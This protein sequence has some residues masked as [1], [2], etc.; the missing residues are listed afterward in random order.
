MTKPQTTTTAA[1]ESYWAMKQRHQ[2]EYSEFTPGKVFFAF[3][4]S[5]FEEGMKSIGLQPT[6]TNKIYR[7]VAGS[8]IR[9][10]YSIE[11]REL[12][13]RFDAEQAAAIA[14]DPT[15]EG[16][17]YSMFYD[18]LTNHEYCYSL[19]SSDALDALGITI[20]DINAD[21]RMKKAFKRAKVAAARSDC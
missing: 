21:E 12:F 1:P 16:F 10:E 2:R 20:D 14:A 17:I 19:D 4:N 11:Q 15:G 13:E 18:E 3:S 7:S 8:F 6:E 5:Q 9:R